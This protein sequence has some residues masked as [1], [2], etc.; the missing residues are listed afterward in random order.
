M[1]VEIKPP[2]EQERPKAPVTYRLSLL[3][4]GP[5]RRWLRER[6]PL[7]PRE[8]LLPQ[9][10]EWT[11]DERGRKVRYPRRKNCDIRQG[12][13]VC[14][15]DIPLHWDEWFVSDEEWRRV[16]PEEYQRG[17]EVSPSAFVWFAAQRGLK[18]KVLYS[19]GIESGVE[20]LP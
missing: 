1:V 15:Y 20:R 11:R 2:P 8:K 17:V 9:A 3:E 16:I 14:G 4:E 6:E 10:E 5:I 13:L 7:I 12:K 19:D 18:Y